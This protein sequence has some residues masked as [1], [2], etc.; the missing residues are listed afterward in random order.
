MSREDEYQLVETCRHL[1]RIGMMPASDGNCSI[2]IGESKALITPT[3][4][5]KEQLKPQDLVQIDL[6][7]DENVEKASS[8][9]RMHAA[10][11][12]ANP[13]INAV[14]HAHPTYL[15]AAGVSGEAPDADLLFET[16]DNVGEIV[17]IPAAEPGSQEYADLVVSKMGNATVGILSKHGAVAVGST[18]EEA[19]FRLERAEH[20]AH[21]VLVSR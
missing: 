19:Q 17:L 12:K 18:I 11:L 7:A 21:I 10:L 6:E 2:R 8:E 15:S 14:V 5:R 4:T 13:E 1:S 3:G 16:R 20:L 9:W